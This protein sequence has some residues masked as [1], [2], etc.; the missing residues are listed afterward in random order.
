MSPERLPAFALPLSRPPA[1]LFARGSDLRI[2]LVAAKRLT[3][4]QRDEIG[5]LY[6]QTLQRSPRGLEE[7]IDATDDFYLGRDASGELVLITGMRRRRV[8]VEGREHILLYT[9]MVALAR[10]CR[11]RG[12]TSRLGITEALWARIS[13]PGTPVHWGFA[14]SSLS[15]YLLMARNFET[16]W[17][18]PERRPPAEI[19]ALIAQMAEGY[20]SYDPE[21]FVVEVEDLSAPSASL[22]IESSAQHPDPQVRFFGEQNPRAID[23]DSL[24]CLAPMTNANLRG[25][26]RR[27]FARLLPRV[28][29]VQL[30]GWAKQ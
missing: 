15:A 20:A 22:E 17:P 26:S 4:A 8:S 23:G 3:R 9:S 14:C 27:Q 28:F 10:S 2:E 1:F 19:Q 6:S 12:L 29:R 21:R 18:R 16:H 24:M 25:I 11:G 30:H 5:A 7:S 13:N